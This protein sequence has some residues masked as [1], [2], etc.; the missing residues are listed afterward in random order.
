MPKDISLELLSTDTSSLLYEE[1]DNAHEYTQASFHFSRLK[2]AD[3]QERTVSA[4]ADIDTPLISGATT[5]R[6]E[7]NTGALPR[8]ILAD[9]T[10]YPLLLEAHSLEDRFKEFSDH[11]LMTILQKIP[12]RQI[13]LDAYV[14]LLTNK[15]IEAPVSFISDFSVFLPFIRQQLS[16]PY[17]IQSGLVFKQSSNI[18]KGWKPYWIECTSTK[19]MLC[20]PLTWKDLADAGLSSEGRPLETP[21][22]VESGLRRS[23]SKLSLKSSA[24]SH[25]DPSFL[26]LAHLIDKRKQEKDLAQLATYVLPLFSTVPV[27]I[28]VSPGDFQFTIQYGGS[29]S[30]SSSSISTVAGDEKFSYGK[31]YIYMNGTLPLLDKKFTWKTATEAAMVDW[32]ILLRD[33]L[34]QSKQVK[35]WIRERG[36]SYTELFSRRKSSVANDQ[37][38]EHPEAEETAATENWDVSEGD[39]QDE[40]LEPSINE[41]EDSSSFYTPQNTFYNTSKYTDEQEDQDEETPPPPT[42]LSDAALE[43]PWAD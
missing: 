36:E 19:Y 8:A 21:A 40:S 1:Q 6:V 42:F 31:E 12:E 27:E 15:I 26:Y 3:P 41:Q 28:S 17:C 23:E 34:S 7:E 24:S 5:R 25:A 10:R 16:M 33:A 43:D 29:S 39:Y 4:L 20:I 37:S 35:K 13:I 2:V 30:T 32:T 38:E 22:P 18:F 9:L 14:M 11:L